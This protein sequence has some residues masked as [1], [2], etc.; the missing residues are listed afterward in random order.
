MKEKIAILKLNKLK[1]RK[2][3]IKEKIRIRKIIRI[4][5]KNQIHLLKL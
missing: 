2:P 3:P 4:K 5:I 1:I